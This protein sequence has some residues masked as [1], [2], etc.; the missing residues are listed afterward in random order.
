MRAAPYTPALNLNSTDHTGIIEEE[1]LKIPARPP[2]PRGL[3]PG[4]GFQNDEADEK[5]EDED[6]LSALAAQYSPAVTNWLA[7]GDTPRRYTK[8][9]DDFLSDDHLAA[10]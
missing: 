9:P 7:A 6:D 8:F 3:T 10:Y 1:L 5:N 2:S 4:K